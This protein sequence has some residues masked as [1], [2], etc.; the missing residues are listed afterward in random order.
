MRAKPR[1][2]SS[3]AHVARTP[4]SDTGSD[5][6]AQAPAE[7]GKEGGPL[8]DSNDLSRV[9]P[10]WVLSLTWGYQGQSSSSLKERSLSRGAEGSVGSLWCRVELRLSP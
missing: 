10:S 5:G 2:L 4:A 1:K 9:N 7:L 3:I 6:D 8:R